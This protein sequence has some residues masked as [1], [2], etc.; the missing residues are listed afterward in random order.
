LVFGESQ[1]L[2]QS[3]RPKAE[4]RKSRS[5][6]DFLKKKKVLKVNE[7]SDRQAKAREL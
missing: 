4:L 3:L 5:V 2:K 6:K 1:G 7:A